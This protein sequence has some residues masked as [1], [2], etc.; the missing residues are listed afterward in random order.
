MIDMTELLVE[1]R[2]SPMTSSLVILNTRE[3]KKTERRQEQTTVE[4]F[5]KQIYSLSLDF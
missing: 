1:P 2:Q 5:L 3:K 4:L